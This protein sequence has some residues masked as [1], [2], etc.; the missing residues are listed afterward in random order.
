[1]NEAA[2]IHRASSEYIYAGSRTDL[3][4]K[5]L[6]AKGDME[7]CTVV[8]W[9]RTLRNTDS[10]KSEKMEIAYQDAWRDDYRC[11]VSF[12]EPTHYIKYYFKLEDRSG[13][14]HYLTNEGLFREMPESGFFE[15]LYTNDS[16]YFSV[17][18]WAKGIVFYQIFPERYKPGNVSKNRHLYE[19]WDSI[20]T[21]DNY[22]GGDLKGIEQSLDYLKELGVGCLYL[23]PIFL[24]DFNHKYATIDY[25]EVDPDF[26]TLDDLKRLVC[27]SHHKGIRILLDGVFNHCGIKFAPFQDVVN[28]DSLSRYSDWFFIHSFPVTAEPLN[29]ECVGDY[30]LMPKLNTSNPEVQDFIIDVMLYWLEVTG[31]D[32]WRLDVADEVDASLWVKARR[33]I[34]ARY[35]N[36]LLIGETWTDGYGLVGDGM[37]LD[38]VMNYL[39]R[40]IM[41]D[42]FAKG[43]IATTDFCFRIGNLLSRYWDEVNMAQYNLLGSHDTTRFLTEAGGDVRKC[44]LAVAF[45][46]LF[47]GSPAI[48]YGEEAGMEGLTD[49][50]CRGG[51]VWDA[52]SRNEELAAWY[53]LLIS[54]RTTH[55]VLRCGSYVQVLADDIRRVFAFERCDGKERFIVFL[56]NGEGTAHVNLSATSIGG[57]W[58]DMMSDAEVRIDEQMMLDSYGVKIFREIL[59][60][61]E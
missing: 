17:P 58:Q 45:Q 43:A 2:I 5:V 60:K 9:K 37:R 22:L 16:D 51:M 54:L 3:Y 10:R 27:N 30:P 35:P 39:F 46:M 41:V 15:Y 47:I 55:H 48:Y 44:K 40:D 12:S 57:V 52:A 32:G 36:A 21:R 31:M 34:K 59:K 8:C 29:Y 7:K 24:A 20:P 6:V 33:T 18:D 53:K 42:Y 49:P 23:T 13:V 26:G 25:K 11:H 61:G 50:L 14:C 56:H 19:R 38:A 1:M 4:F 28:N